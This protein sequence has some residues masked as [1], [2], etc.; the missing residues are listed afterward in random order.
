MY[1]PIR[2]TSL[3]SSGSTL[4]HIMTVSGNNVPSKTGHPTI[5]KPQ[6][7]KLTDYDLYFTND[8][9]PSVIPRSPY[10]LRVHSPLRHDG[11]HSLFAA[12]RTAHRAPVSP[13]EQPHRSGARNMAGTRCVKP[14]AR[15]GDMGG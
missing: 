9:H 6:I 5:R 12:G 3:Q 1:I 8:I 2:Q 15:R 11:R 10:P 13:T 4:R 7:Q 14:C